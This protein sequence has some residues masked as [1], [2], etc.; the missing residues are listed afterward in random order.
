MELR[1]LRCFLAVAEEENITRAAEVLRLSQSVVSR[2]LRQLET[3]LGVSLVDRSTHHLHL[4]AAGVLYR[5]RAAAALA[6]VDG[7]FDP[8]GLG[9]WPIRLGQA[10]SALGDR[11]SALVRGWKRD[12]PETPLE[13]RRIDDETAGL[14]TGSA[15]VVI[16]RG[17]LPPGPWR[18]R[19]ILLEPRL[20]VVAADNELASRDSVTL[21]DLARFPLAL[22]S[23]SGTTTVD[24]WP[25][26]ARPS[27]VVPVH[28]TDE[29]LVVV[30]AGLAV[31]VTSTATESAYP[32]PGVVYLP[33]TD[34]PALPVWL[35]WPES[36][37]HPEV[38][39]LIRYIAEL[40][41]D[42]APATSGTAPPGPATSASS[43]DS[44]R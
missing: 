18:H 28:N 7:V 41:T 2:T 27:E 38:G 33:L 40:V 24:L 1:H 42:A 5:P 20:A 12:H 26:A 21:A 10:W 14:A 17:T 8:A 39:T 15:D 13:L 36:A 35:V 37:T 34:G 43:A 32:H 11:T 44:G 16:L 9:R 25:P 30:A 23:R 6:A 3:H 31:G 22:N 4:T 29:W 19:R